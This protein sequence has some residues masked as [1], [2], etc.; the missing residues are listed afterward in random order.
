MI[1]Q[2]HS[3][4]AYLSL[5]LALVLAVDSGWRAWRA[6]AGT[7]PGARLDPIL[8]IATGVAAAGGLGIY[9]G[10]GRPHETL[11]F[12]YGVLALGAIPVANSLGRG[13]SARQVAIARFIGAVVAVVV[14]WR[15]FQT[16]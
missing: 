6:K 8:L 1:A 16:G 13:R 4:L 5:G 2:L 10:G 11:H 9:V 12:V 3:A 7:A 14:I 15:L